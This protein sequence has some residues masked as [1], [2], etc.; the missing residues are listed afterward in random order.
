[1]RGDNTVVC[2]NGGL[3]VCIVG[4]TY[5]HSV[6]IA[7]EHLAEHMHATKS[8]MDLTHGRT[9]CMLGFEAVLCSL[10]MCTLE[11]TRL[12]CSKTWKCKARLC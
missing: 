11:T 5:G 6:G 3:L 4:H 9:T 7:Q 2:N 8:D 12:P 1:M 10:A